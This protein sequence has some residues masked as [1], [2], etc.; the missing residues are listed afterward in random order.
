MGGVGPI[1]ARKEPSFCW[2]YLSSR[3]ICGPAEDRQLPLRVR[4]EVGKCGCA[5]IGFLAVYISPYIGIKAAKIDSIRYCRIQVPARFSW[6]SKEENELSARYSRLLSVEMSQTHTSPL[7]PFEVTQL[8]F[9][10]RHMTIQS[11][12]SMSIFETWLM[13][14]LVLG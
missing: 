11:M 2:I 14:S 9:L 6:V 1:D 7:S 8:S 4:W 10:N 13:N 5:D 3:E 12:T